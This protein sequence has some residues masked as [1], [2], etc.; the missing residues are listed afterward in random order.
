MVFPVAALALMVAIDRVLKENP[1]RFGDRAAIPS[2][3]NEDF[4]EPTLVLLHKSTNAIEAEAELEFSCILTVAKLC[5]GAEKTEEK[6]M[7]AIVVC[8]IPWDLG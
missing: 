6:A 1:Y 7:E 3:K 8:W 4:E 2:R 5:K